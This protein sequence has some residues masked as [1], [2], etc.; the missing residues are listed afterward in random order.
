MRRR[1]THIAWTGLWS[2]VRG[3]MGSHAVVG[4][5]GLGDG[6]KT[7]GGEDGVGMVVANTVNTIERVGWEWF[8]GVGD[9]ERREHAIGFVE[10][11]CGEEHGG[12]GWG[13]EIGIERGGAGQGGHGGVSGEGGFSGEVGHL[14]GEGRVDR[15]ARWATSRGRGSIAVVLWG[16]DDTGGKG[17]LELKLGGERFGLRAASRR[18]GG[19]IIFVFEMCRIPDPRSVLFFHWLPLFVVFLT[20]VGGVRLNDE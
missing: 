1:G 15:R 2:G 12:R 5:W 20:R 10:E 3:F 13:L 18:R 4:R 11:L 7:L 9:D 8:G 17:G 14:S 16:T 6:V 19:V